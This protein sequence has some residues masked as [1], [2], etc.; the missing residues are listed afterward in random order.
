MQGISATLAKSHGFSILSLR[1]AATLLLLLIFLPAIAQ[2]PPDWEN[3]KLTGINNQPPH[4]AF[5]PYNTEAEALTNN[6]WA[7][8][9]IMILNGNWKFHWSE[10]PEKR[11]SDFY[12]DSYDVSGWG[13]IKVPSTLELQGYG[14]PVYVNQPYEFIHLMKPDPPHVPK[15]YNP[16][17]SYRRDFDVPSSWKEREVFLRF[18]NV[19]SFCYVYLNG[20]RIGMAKDGKT[21]IEFDVTKYLR[22]GKNTIGVEVFR[23]SDGTYLE[24]QDMWRMSGINHDVYLF[25][26]PKTRIRDFFVTGDLFSDYR[27]G[28]LKLTTII[29]NEQPNPPA[30]L[31][32]MYLLPEYILEV[33]LYENKL[34]QQPL[35]REAIPFR[36]TEKAEDT[37][38]FEKHI[39]N[40]RLWSAEIPNLYN[41]VILLKDK[42]GNI[43]ESTGSRMGFRSA[44]V[45]NGQ[46][47]INGKA[48]LLKGVN[49]H[50]HDPV[51]GHVITKEM[52]QKDIRL[53]KECNINTVRTC[54]Y[55]DA[56]YWYELCNEYG[57]YVIDE[58]NIESHGM[59]YNPDKTLGNNPD[60][61]EAHLNRTIRMVER[62]K[63]NPCIIIWSLGNEAGNGCN[64]EAT[65][66]WIKQRDKSRPVWYERAEQGA[67]T[68]IFC[69]MYWSPQ[70]LKWYGYSRQLRPLIMCEYAHAMGNS[71]GN[72]KDYWDV[73][74]KYPQL[75][76]GCIWD[77]VDQGLLVT[78]QLKGFKGKVPANAPSD[79]NRTDQPP[80]YR[81]EQ[82]SW[83]FGG[84]FGPDN[85]PSDGN[86]LCNGIVF[87]DRQ[88][89]P[90][91]WEVK[92]VYQYV[93]FNLIDPDGAS[94]EISNHY[95]F[96]DL[97]NTEITWDLIAN[98]STITSGKVESGTVVPGGKKRIALQLPGMNPSVKTEYFLNVYL[99]TTKAWGLLGTGHILASEQ[100]ILP[101]L[102]SDPAAV[103]LKS[104]LKVSE[105]PQSVE[106]TGNDFSCVFNRNAG[107]LSSIKYGNSEILKAGPVPNF[108]RAPTDNDIGNGMPKRC[109]AWFDASENRSV[110]KMQVVSAESGNV[111]I[112]VHFSLPENIASETVSY[113]ITPDRKIAVTSTIKPLKE[114]LPEMP[115]F[116]LNL[117]LSPQFNQV[118]YYGR[119][120]WE[121]YCDRKTA[122]FIGVYK[123]TVDDLFTPY[124]RPQENGYRTEVRWVEFTDS[125]NAGVRFTGSPVIC[126]SALPY[127]YD[128]LKGFKQG[129]KHLGDLEKKPFIDLNLD[130][131]QTGVGGDD[132]WGA[133][134][135]QQ[136]T[137]QAKE[138]SYS[139]TI[140]PLKSKK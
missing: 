30:D 56:P 128:D 10:N 20:E 102:G 83:A 98:G 78:P 100:L 132:S 28:I 8:P 131:G 64:F 84:D 73:I 34:S 17:G 104:S 6:W 58:A 94:F 60:W 54:H 70:D 29:K 119:G 122:S 47:L 71:T 76:G 121:N 40:P 117:Q 18:V 138:Y 86:F 15:A 24:S 57:L 120:P 22:D 112:V 12:K 2:T 33:A 87:P 95:D 75:Q 88:P 124:V 127:T 118:A 44:E 55:P 5:L 50:E 52:M 110:S 16:V 41:L 133:R 13:D 48:V 3:P 85:V 61:K 107:T 32:R 66:D 9:W 126:F 14:Y 27:H 106:I 139:F 38:Y 43:I 130:Y 134:P 90:G 1:T 36:M 79:I 123:S 129:G 137:L 42:E 31:D 89:H 93:K 103:T 23:W 19:K 4:A 96:Y 92:K 53:M 136:Y 7:S 49:R 68:D 80:A 81:Y 21:P 114:K 37:L 11:P 46:F 25:S 115:R 97:R 26:T 82:I 99:K 108:R 74:E 67:N 101:V 65:Y 69:P 109:Q 62:D 51:L 116:G 72:F 111:E 105:N 91:Y 39:P 45:K 113:I 63:N 135:H 77:W 35:I 59:G 140:E 125:N